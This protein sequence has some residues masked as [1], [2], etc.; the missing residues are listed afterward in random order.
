MF[1]LVNKDFQLPFQWYCYYSINAV[2]HQVLYQTQLTL[3]ILKSFSSGGTRNFHLGGYSPGGGSSP[4]GFR[5]ETPVGGLGDEVP[6][7]LK[8][9]ADMVDRF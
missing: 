2:V 9:F 3:N 1:C 8:Q 7:K 6:K 5:V 4:V